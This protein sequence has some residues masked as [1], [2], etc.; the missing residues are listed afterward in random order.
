MQI[1]LSLKKAEQLAQVRDLAGRL[2]VEILAHFYQRSEVR[3]AADWVGGSYEVVERALNSRAEAVMVCGACF[4]TAEIQR[5]G[6]EAEL[7]IP[8]NDLSCPLA[9]AVSQTDLA[10]IRRIYP[11]A[12]IV[13]DMKAQPEI[14][15]L[16]DIKISPSN[17]R[18]LLKK[19]DRKEIIA[20]PGPQL[21]DWAGFGH[22]IVAR[23]PQAVCRVHELALPED[24]EKAK[25][26]HPNALV[27]AN[28][29][30][31]PEIKTQ[32]DFVGDSAAIKKFCENSPAMEFI[33]ISEAGLA[34]HLSAIRPGKIY[35]ET[36]AEIFCPNMKLTTLKSMIT[37][38]QLFAGDK[39]RP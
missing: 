28:L 3:A 17:A 1:E 33:V 11:G 30:C 39:D 15:E 34:D 29:L 12:L 9:E 14:Q 10:E 31:R 25:K 35:H 13:A 20:L 26:D 23:W 2:G 5:R 32:A 19:L 24:M 37:R 6:I 8:R 16:A 22:L 21:V 27:A 18:E 36:E 4:M 7:L 38:L